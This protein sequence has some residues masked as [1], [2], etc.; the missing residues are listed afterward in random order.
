MPDQRPDAEIVVFGLDEDIWTVPAD[1]AEHGC[2][3]ED[4]SDEIR[5]GDRRPEPA[6]ATFGAGAGA[7]VGAAPRAATAGAFPLRLIGGRTPTRAQWVAAVAA[8]VVV[9]FLAGLLVGRGTG[10]RSP[11]DSTTLTLAT[12]A[13]RPP[14]S[15][16]ATQPS[17]RLVPL[18]PIPLPRGTAG[19]KGD[20]AAVD[21][22]ALQL[23][24]RSANRGGQSL[25]RRDAGSVNG[26][27]SLIVRRSDGF[28]GHHS[29]VITY[30]ISASAWVSGQ[31]RIRVG[32]VTGHGDAFGGIL[33]PIDGKY[34]RIRGDLGRTVLADLA[35]RVS[36][37]HRHPVLDRPTAGLRV[38]AA[39][40]YRARVVTESRYAS[41][42]LL[43]SNSI[44]GLVYTGVLRGASFEEALLGEG[45]E[46][47]ANIGGHPAVTSTVGGGNATLA[48]EPTP[49]LIVFVG[50]SGGQ[51]VPA[52]TAALIEL[53]RAGRVL[54]HRQ[55]TATK[56]AVVQDTNV[57]S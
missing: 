56:P 18:E 11:A 43:G 3:A 53:A 6:D 49:G 44:D 16:P 23:G 30:P 15:V 55:W 17:W 39:E 22:Y 10:S 20:V 57:Y 32:T 52:S 26:P 1:A 40:P 38:V 12:S 42:L 21:L 33:W 9:A 46:P 51:D 24:P 34:A 19:P 5:Q 54:D 8:L 41:G 28:L 29:S 35:A 48:W 47:G 50:Y 4:A 31:P 36:V 13:A 7:D 2:A 14:R 45:T 37:R 25:E 27:W